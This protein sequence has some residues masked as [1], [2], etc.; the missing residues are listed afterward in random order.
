M[1]KE[2]IGYKVSVFRWNREDADILTFYHMSPLEMYDWVD[3]M[4]SDPFSDITHV[5]LEEFKIK[6]YE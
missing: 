6:D 3:D 5:V 2:K 4:L 1:V